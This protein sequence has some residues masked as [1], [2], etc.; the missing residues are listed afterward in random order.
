VYIGLDKEE[1]EKIVHC[2]AKNMQPG[3]CKFILGY[4]PKKKII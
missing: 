1:K 2:I 4:L 3:D